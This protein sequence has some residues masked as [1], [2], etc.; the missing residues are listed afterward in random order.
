MA[1]RIDDLQCNG[2]KIIQ[3]TE[4]FCFGMDAVLLANYALSAVTNE[5]R[6]LDLCSGTGIVPLLIAAK[7]D[8][9]ELLGLE[10]QK[11]VSDMAKRSIEMNHEEYRMKMIQGDLK[12]IK[13]MKLASSMNV[14]TCNP[15]YMSAGLLNTTDRKLISR[16]EVMCTLGDV[17]YAAA[18]ALKS[19]GKFY[20]VHRP[21]RLV[22]IFNELRRVHLE[23]KRM[24]LIYPYEYSEA[25]MVLLEAV[26]GGKTQLI[27]EKPL[28]VY[29]DKN[30]Y[31]DELLS[32][33]AVS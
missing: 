1:E 8:C 16:H 33:Y 25:N 30:I 22:D 12:E 13:E 15:P 19:N 11:D 10:L 23:P 20:M 6:L 28:I 17:C 7:T 32:I 21:N 18:Y 31:T 4:G 27:V 14:V 3:D 26:K 5:T 24:R 29:K 9:K 2:Y